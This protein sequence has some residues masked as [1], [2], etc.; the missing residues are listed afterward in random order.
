MPF[1]GPLFSRDCQS[2]AAFFFT[3]AA[4]ARER[5]GEEEERKDGGVHVTTSHQWERE[6]PFPSTAP[7]SAFSRSPSHR[8]TERSQVQSRRQSTPESG[9]V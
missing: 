5:E 6:S 2:V 4:R 8:P 3:G 1:K 7:P 9:V